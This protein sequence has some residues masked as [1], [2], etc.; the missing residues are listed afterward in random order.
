MTSAG[1][2]LNITKLGYVYPNLD[3]DGDGLINGLEY[4]IGTNPS[5]TDTDNDGINDS[6]AYPL[7]GLPQSDPN[8]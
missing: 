6:T 4:L 3:S 8:S 7:A 5:D 2:N 1:Y